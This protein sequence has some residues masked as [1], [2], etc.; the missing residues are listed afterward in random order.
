MTDVTVY[1]LGN[2]EM[3]EYVLNGVA[4]LAN[5]NNDLNV[6]GLA[7]LGF[8]IGTIG[9]GLVAVISQRLEP[10]KLLYGFILFYGMF[11]PTASVGIQD[12]YSAEVAVVDNVPVGVAYPLYAISQTGHWL[13]TAFE[14][15][16]SVPDANLS[17][18][19]MNSLRV[20]NSLRNLNAGKGQVAATVERSL[21]NYIQ[22]CVRYAIE[23]E[24]LDPA[25]KI[26]PYSILQNPE[27]LSGMAT[28]YVNRDVQTYI[29]ASGLQTSLE[30][31][32]CGD[33]YDALV[34]YMETSFETDW[35][36]SGLTGDVVKNDKDNR[37][38]VSEVESAANSLGVNLESGYKYM[39]N[40][41][42]KNAAKCALA[43]QCAMMT[44]AIEQRHAEWYGN[45][46]MFLEVARP[47]MAFIE[48]LCAA[49]TPLMAFMLG[50]GPQGVAMASKYFLMLIW[51]SLWQPLLAVCN[52]YINVAAAKELKYLGSQLDITS[53]TGI[54]ATWT[55]IESWLGTGNLM[56]SSVP[57]LALMLVYGG[58]VA[59]TS[60]SSRM[61]SG[62]VDPSIVNPSLASMGPLYQKAPFMSEGANLTKNPTAGLHAGGAEPAF[63][64]SSASSAVNSNVSNKSKELSQSNTQ[65]AAAEEAM[66]ETF[67]TTASN[68][69][70]HRS[71]NATSAGSKSSKTATN[72]LSNS[73]AHDF[74]WDKKQAAEFA[75]AVQAAGD[76]VTQGKMTP[77]AAEMGL[78]KLAKS[79]GLAFNGGASG[80][81]RGT[82][83]SSEHEAI[84]SALSSAYQ[85]SQS[86][87]AEKGKT[88]TDE[89]SNTA[90]RIKSAT[91][92]S[93]AATRLSVAKANQERATQ[94][95]MEAAALQRQVGAATT[96][97][98]PA[99]SQKLAANAELASQV[100]DLARTMVPDKLEKEAANQS[101]QKQWY[102]S[103]KAG[104]VDP[105]M[106]AAG[107]LSKD[108][109]GSAA[110]LKLLAQHGQLGSND[111]VNDLT[112]SSNKGLP[113]DNP[114]LNGTE[115]KAA[116]EV[117]NKSKPRAVRAG[118]A[119]RRDGAP[120][121]KGAGLPA[122]GPSPFVT[123]PGGGAPASSA[124]STPSSGGSPGGGGGST[125]SH[126]PSASAPTGGVTPGGG[127]PATSAPS[128]P[129]SGGSPG[130]GGSSTAS[131]AV[132]T[133]PASGGGAPRPAV[134]A[135][136]RAP[137][138]SAPRGGSKS[139]G[140]APG[141]SGGIKS[142]D[143]AYSEALD[144]LGGS[145]WLHSTPSGSLAGP[146]PIA[147]AHVLNSRPS[148]AVQ[149][150]G[151]KL[152]EGAA[153]GKIAAQEAGR[154]L[155]D[156][157]NSMSTEELLAL[158]AAAG[159][160]MAATSGVGGHAVKAS[161][162]K[163][164]E[165]ANSQWGKQAAASIR[166]GLSSL[167]SN[168]SKMARF[169][170]SPAG[171]QFL[172]RAAAATG[173]RALGGLAGSPVASGLLFTAG[174]AVTAKEVYDMVKEEA[175]AGPKEN[176]KVIPADQTSVLPP[177]M[178]G[179]K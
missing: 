12:A 22:Q 107:A 30:T 133:S 56:A 5:G 87:T 23:D 95:Y 46:E 128:A 26:S 102:H 3:L 6:F 173:A 134:G 97:S 52:L 126:A 81:A 15:A 171:R 136:S 47:M 2:S 158:G 13:T 7:K 62:H 28:Y 53:G 48:I 176:S 89:I 116:N 80:T 42:L 142:V 103:G 160:S 119:A 150:A 60:L 9:V 33:A 77:G 147:S 153:S 88:A 41:L 65:L 166:S 101:A 73:L 8:L 111:G 58:S 96:L 140:G 144:E 31:M 127:A 85:E 178:A 36:S 115:A 122:P 108:A 125:A 104:K 164:A 109:E 146:D 154:A 177:S 123:T 113:V 99:L 114:G 120:L 106:V 94:S 174:L 105:N 98:A 167:A 74:G 135:P 35:K 170:A 40:A 39:T 130:G 43:S 152:R 83:G 149:A 121:A 172:G 18:G 131:P 84:K 27:V 78:S 161:G 163:L 112:P 169:A 100:R 143:Q 63:S 69:F 34:S 16:Y 92:S 141:K 137:S 54:D 148:E 17:K 44:Q 24:Y 75:A 61:N 71:A 1:S 179:K 129:S 90:S 139:S 21:L 110:L 93:T 165:L 50:L 32:S 175:P 138:A 117:W 68:A 4:M 82:A 29:N 37:D 49:I 91:G 76:L 155:M 72:Q 86:R 25:D 151:N 157:V 67:A 64:L 132:A 118:E 145:K 162:R 55:T 66:A 19:Y 79:M 57:A 45:K 51:V 10:Q 70:A 38:P 20:L 124:P 159:L 11:V 14:T 156:T 59:A 168:G